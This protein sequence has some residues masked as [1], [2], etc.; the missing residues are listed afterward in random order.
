W[1]LGETHLGGYAEKARVKGDWLV[2]L[3]ARNSARGAM[4]VGTA[5]YTALLA[6]GALERHGIT[7]RQRAVIGPGAARGLGSDGR[8]ATC[9]AGLFCHRLDR[10]S[11]RGGLP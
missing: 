9:Q 6:G 7:P 4:A 11:G 2:R 5:G 1:G 10:T 3:P 8:G